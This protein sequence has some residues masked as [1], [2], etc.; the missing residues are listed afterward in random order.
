M[1]FTE[2][3][4]FMFAFM[5]IVLSLGVVFFK[6]QVSAAVCLVLSFLSMFPIWLMLGAEFLSLSLVLVYVGAVLVL[7]LF[8][9]MMIDFHKTITGYGNS[10]WHLAT[11]LFVLGIAGLFYQEWQGINLGIN[12][13]SEHN[14]VELAKLIFSN[15]LIEFILAGVILLLAIVAS[16]VLA[17]RGSK[18]R[19]G[20]NI[21]TQLQASK[22]NRLRLMND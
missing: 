15:F 6:Q 13:S 4:F 2:L 17:Y 16:I 9:L 18:N 12:E 10:L 5:T 21:E 7:F 22:A 8:V 11:G 19:L 1:K 3:L 14:V 20:Q